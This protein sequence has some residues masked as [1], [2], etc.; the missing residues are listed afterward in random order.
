MKIV[1]CIRQ[2]LDGEIN[3]FDACAYE[4]ALR[5]ESAEVTILSMG[6]SSAKDFLHS[7]TRLGAK[8]AILLCDK[9]FAGADTLATAYALSC[10]I[11]TLQPDLVFCGR[12]TL[13]GDTAQTGP[14]LSEMLG[15]GLITNVMSIDAISDSIECT[16]RDENKETAT[17]P[18]LITVERINNLRLPRLRSKLSEIEV[19]TAA[20]IGAEALQLVLYQVL[21]MKQASANANLSA[22]ICSNLQ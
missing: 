10:A 22:K 6:P 16:T 17:L 12:Q 15:F 7:L 14:M 8:K 18:A 21:R 11:K 2:G 3:P 5:I 9:V 13:V 4:E 20:D 19:L 1:V